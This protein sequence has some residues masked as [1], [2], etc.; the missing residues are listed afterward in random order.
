M[1][2]FIIVALSFLICFALFLLTG[3]LIGWALGISD[4]TRKLDQL[5]NIQTEIAIRQG[6]RMDSRGRW[7]QP[8]Q[9]YSDFPAEPDGEVDQATLDRLYNPAEVPRRPE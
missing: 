4:I 6:L 3:R 5:V 9:K 8:G 7:F 2:D 1:A